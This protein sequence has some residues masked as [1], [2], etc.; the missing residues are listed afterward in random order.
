M[1]L[2][3]EAQNHKLIGCSMP[4]L[5]IGEWHEIGCETTRCEGIAG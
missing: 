2:V 4:E 3:R 1:T 5:E